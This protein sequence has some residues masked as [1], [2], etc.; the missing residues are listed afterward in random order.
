MLTQDP[1]G[2]RDSIARVK[3]SAHAAALNDEIRQA[4]GLLSRLK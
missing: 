2:L 1:K 3:S 4:E